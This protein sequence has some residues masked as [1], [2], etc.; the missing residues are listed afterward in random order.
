MNEK[1]ESACST[2]CS[3]TNDH[4]LNAWLCFF[5]NCIGNCSG[6]KVSLVTLQCDELNVLLAITIGYNIMFFFEWTALFG[7]FR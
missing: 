6:E 3:R 2:R 4:E 5:A 7:Q 1:N